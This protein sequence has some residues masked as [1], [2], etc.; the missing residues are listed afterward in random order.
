MIKV[1][2]CSRA[3]WL[4]QFL[5]SFAKLFKK[6]CC[7]A[8]RD[9]VQTLSQPPR[10]MNHLEAQIIQI[11]LKL[12]TNKKTEG[13]EIVSFGAHLKYLIKQACHLILR[14]PI[15]CLIESGRS[16][17]PREQQLISPRWHLCNQTRL[18]SYLQLHRIALL[19]KSLS[20]ISKLGFIMT[21][22]R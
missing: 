19:V 5:G 3:I 20:A 22:E 1:S 12:A 15:K 16:E 11:K 7:W 17:G 10:W 2:L 6:F 14:F 9:N 4:L 21:W 8:A 18:P 13:K